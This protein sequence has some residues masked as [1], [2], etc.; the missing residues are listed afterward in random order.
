MCFFSIAIAFVI[1]VLF[2]LVV[3]ILLVVV[4]I[5]FSSWVYVTLVFVKIIIFEKE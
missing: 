4:V 1:L 2:V 5:I 3:L